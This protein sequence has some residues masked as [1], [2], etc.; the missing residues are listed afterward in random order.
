M[1]IFFEGIL[2]SDGV[3]AFGALIVYFLRFDRKY[4]P[5]RLLALLTFASSVWSLS[6]GFFNIQVLEKNA[7]IARS[8]G[9]FGTFT[10]MVAA[11]M[12]LCE[13][14]GLRKRITITLNAIAI[15]GYAIYIVELN[16]KYIVY[17]VSDWGMTYRFAPGIVS[18]VYTVYFIIVSLNII[19]IEIFMMKSNSNRKKAFGRHF[20][21]VE[22]CVLIGTI[23]DVIAPLFGKNS[24]PGSVIMQFFGLVVS[25][26][27]V[28]LMNRTRVSPETMS[29]HLYYSVHTPIL[30]YDKDRGLVVVN[31]AAI[32]F[33]HLDR[34][35]DLSGLRL[36]D[37]FEVPKD[38]E[39][40]FADSEVEENETVCLVNNVTV[41]L[42]VNRI[43]DC[44]NDVLGYIAI[45]TDLT[46]QFED[47]KRLEEAKIEADEANKAKSAFL[48]NMSHEI[49]TP[50]N[51]IMGFAELALNDPSLPAHLKDYVADIKG[52]SNT[53]LASINDI[54]NISKI[55]SGKM[56]IVC[57]D[58]S[59]SSLLKNVY[60]IISVQAR[61]KKLDFKITVNGKLPTVLYGDDLRI[62]EVLIN[63][64]NN[65][66]KYTNKGS[67]ELIVSS[68]NISPTEICLRMSVKDTG[69]GI[70]EEDRKKLF[71][72][73][74]R[75]D[76]EKNHRTEGTGLGLSIVYGYIALM[77]GTIDVSSVYGEGSEFIVAVDQKVIDHMPCVINFRESDVTTK[78]ELGS[79]KVKDTKVLICDDNR[80]NLK[81]IS[82]T[83]NAFGIEV[84]LAASGGEA[85]TMC[86]EIKYPIVF[87]DHMMP[88]MDGVEAM[89]RIREMSD[90]YKDEAKIVV[91]TANAIEG[92]REELTDQG[93]DEYLSKPIDYSE[94]ARVLKEYISPDKIEE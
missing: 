76:L 69:I 57:E 14:S 42:Q 49:R 28:D 17:E 72:A 13:I 26:Y 38:P 40:F 32:E 30:M 86:H 91:L 9:I 65:A 47:R 87:M 7:H 8:F 80:V 41:N 64:L 77:G 25:W 84:D 22:L 39:L 44:Y 60:N 19:A 10:Y 6:F 36:K 5:N 68:E 53:L 89:H 93:F 46:P 4:K 23:F 75:V 37:L 67:V 54:L 71:A 24:I 16:P 88:E 52:A 82:K 73:Y 74:E 43:R 59:I 70:K 12:L 90:Y 50:V 81:V 62:Q 3:L 55:E 63:L 2:L 94:L 1:K 34:K 20:L 15:S 33:L 85:I 83:L 18:T 61:N 48:A 92:V 29:E 11:Q 35:N 58:Y 79:F 21:I 78:T 56:E 66:V 45:V 31:D 27:A 51:A